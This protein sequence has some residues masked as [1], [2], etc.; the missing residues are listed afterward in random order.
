MNQQNLNLVVKQQILR[1]Q[2]LE[3]EVHALKQDLKKYSSTISAKTT[4]TAVEFVANKT[5]RRA[6]EQIN[7]HKWVEAASIIADQYGGDFMVKDSPNFDILKKAMYEF[8]EMPE[9]PNRFDKSSEANTKRERR[10][11]VK[12]TVYTYIDRMG[13]YYL[14]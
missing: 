14:K 7:N 13:K 5:L 4:S 11:A 10:K 8:Y 9:A 6:I 12:A 3:S 2:Q 1:I